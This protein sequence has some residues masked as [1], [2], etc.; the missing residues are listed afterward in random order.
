M[1]LWS[2]ESCQDIQMEVSRGSGLTGLRQEARVVFGTCH[3]DGPTKAK[4]RWSHPGRECREGR[5]QKPKPGEHQCLRSL[6]RPTRNVWNAWLSGHRR[7]WKPTEH[8]TERSLIILQMAGSP[9]HLHLW[10]EGQIVEGQVVSESQAPVA[11]TCNPSYSGG[12][13]Q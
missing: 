10:G 13:D 9:L 7:E 12:R 4:S 2:L 3:V 1:N 8:A 5:S 11:H 6:H